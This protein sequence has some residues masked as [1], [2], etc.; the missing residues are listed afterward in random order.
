MY[1]CISCSSWR[2]FGDVSEIGKRFLN[3]SHDL[4][5]FRIKNIVRVLNKIMLE[6][7]VSNVRFMSSPVSLVVLNLSVFRKL[8]NKSHLRTIDCEEAGG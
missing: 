7:V 1:L 2:I 3:M 5:T 6:T 8:F 4:W